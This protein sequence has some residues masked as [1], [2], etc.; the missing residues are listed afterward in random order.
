VYSTS[1]KQVLQQEIEKHSLP[2]DFFDTIENWYIP[3]AQEIARQHQQKK[4]TLLINVNGSQ[5]SGKS[6]L[7]AFLSL[8]L[9]HHFGLNTIDI[10]IDDFYL[11]KAQRKKLSK[12]VH[13][14]LATRGVPGT[15]DIQLAVDCMQKLSHK[16]SCTLPQFNKAI[17]DRASEKSWK[18]I[19]KPVDIILFEGWCTAA[20]FQEKEAL[21][22]PINTLE[23]EEDPDGVWRSY[24]N[25]QLKAYHQ[26][27]FNLSDYLIFLQIPNFEKVYEW[28]WLQEEKL[29]LTA[30]DNQ[31]VMTRQQ[32]HRF[33]QHYERITRNCLELLPDKANMTVKLSD[34]HN[35]VS[36]DYSGQSPIKD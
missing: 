2:F 8:I 14:L 27:L 16:Q 19:D 5:G 21:Q 34:N 4:D 6:T 22:N 18:Q 11:T 20:P 1:V 28:R 13:P 12:D 25:E 10:S 33:I 3:I 30:S 17:D 32:V 23:S 7:T 26:H 29:A 15:H 31:A 35:I 36:L 9:T 24:V